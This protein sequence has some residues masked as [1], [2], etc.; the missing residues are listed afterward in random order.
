VANTHIL[1]GSNN[2]VKRINL[3]DM[4]QKSIA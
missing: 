3:L 2:M 1:K 4:R